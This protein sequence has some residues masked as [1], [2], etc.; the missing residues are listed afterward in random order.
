MLAHSAPAGFLKI[1]PDCVRRFIAAYPQLV[2]GDRLA[3]HV[4]LFNHGAHQGVWYGEDYAFC[5][6]WRDAG[7]QIW[8]IPNL[9]INHHTADV[10]YAGN[11]HQWLLRQPGGSHHDLHAAP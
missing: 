2:Y 11:F 4:D 8:L 5:R 10:M 3:P 6:N 1:T 7:G 9:D